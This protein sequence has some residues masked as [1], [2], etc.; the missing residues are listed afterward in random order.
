MEKTQRRGSEKMNKR[1]NR[2][3]KSWVTNWDVRGNAELVP[4]EEL[5]GK[6]RTR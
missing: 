1:S 6:K 3:D 4:I 5:D 2:G